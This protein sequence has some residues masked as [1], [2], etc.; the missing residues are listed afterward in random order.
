[1]TRLYILILINCFLGELINIYDH[2]IAYAENSISSDEN[3]KLARREVNQAKAV[4]KQRKYLQAV[5]HLEQAYRYAPSV[6]YLFL[7]ARLYDRLD[8]Q[9]PL[10]L[11]TWDRVLHNCV[12]CPLRG[13]AESM[14]E[15]TRKECLVSL[16]L[17]IQPPE[18]QVYLDGRKVELLSDRIKIPA[19]SYSL[20]LVHQRKEVFKEIK[21][22]RGVKVAKESFNLLNFRGTHAPSRSL[23]KPLSSQ[24]SSSENPFSAK[25]IPSSTSVKPPVLSDE[26]VEEDLKLFTSRYLQS[27]AKRSISPRHLTVEDDP[28]V[29][30][31]E[32]RK[33]SRSRIWKTIH[34]GDLTLKTRM[35][36]QYLTRLND[37]EPVEECD[38]LPLKE[39][40]RLR[41]EVEVNQ[42]VYLYLIVT[43][44]RTSWQLIYPMLGESNYVIWKGAFYLP[45]NEWLL[46]DNSRQTIEDFSIIV[47]RHPIQLLEQNREVEHRGQVPKEVLEYMV[48]LVESKEISALSRAER[49][50]AKVS[51]RQPSKKSKEINYLT[52]SFQVFR[53]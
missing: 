46:L 1:M 4:I 9:C 37:Y 23:Q 26:T 30:K 42:P 28:F 11:K 14:A 25:P 52:L 13:K 35:E 48:P 5:D 44:H 47:S 34:R 17:D 50:K 32:D 45:E 51:P 8:D 10:A 43:N 36:C 53:R 39:K 27:R 18:T 7:M 40:D 38:G 16:E 21:L 2:S 24:E 31:A 20:R 33:Q 29:V 41:F 49:Q 15:V 22:K 6:S 12:K 3:I 19:Q